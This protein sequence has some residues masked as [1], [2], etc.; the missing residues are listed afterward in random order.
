MLEG[1]KTGTQEISLEMSDECSLILGVKWIRKLSYYI[2][3][4]ILCTGPVFAP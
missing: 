4:P 1:K 3:K 2:Y